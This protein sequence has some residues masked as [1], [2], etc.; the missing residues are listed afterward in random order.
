MVSITQFQL[1]PRL[2]LCEE[3]WFGVKQGLRSLSPIANKEEPCMSRDMHWRNS[4][5]L[6]P[7]MLSH[8]PY[9]SH[10]MTR[11]SHFQARTSVLGWPRALP[12]WGSLVPWQFDRRRALAPP[13]P[14][15][16]SS[17][18]LRDR[19]SCPRYR[20]EI[21]WVNQQ[22]LTVPSTGSCPTAQGLWGSPG[23]HPESH[24]AP[25]CPI[26]PSGSSQTCLV[27]ADFP[28]QGS[29]CYS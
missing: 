25:A 6:R 9:S 1:R 15:L 19:W 29:H 23:T 2:T 14:K 12:V 26:S 13:A 24:T 16:S 28:V 7:L 5:M 8:S 4:F 21:P 18:L 10:V 17:G 20:G 27:C 22:P 3:A 11:S